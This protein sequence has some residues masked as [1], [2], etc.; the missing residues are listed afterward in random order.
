MPLVLERAVPRDA[1]AIAALRMASAQRL[2][3]RHGEGP[4]SFAT[5]SEGG[6]R[7]EILGSNVF[8]ARCGGR[9]LASL[10]LSMRNPWL[11]DISFFSASARPL[12][13]TSMVVALR[14]Q[15]R[16][17]GRQCLIQALQHARLLNAD[18]VRLDTY[19][20]PAGAEDFY[21]K[22][23]FREVH[24]AE[25]HG[26]PLVWFERSVGESARATAEP[27]NSAALGFGLHYRAG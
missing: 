12:Y 16:G 21:R 13:L 5:E 23:G 8:V 7:A 20:S 9:L 18:V 1:A 2:A 27:Y 3:R 15:G 17:V 10:R 25:Y 4:W 11:G 6:L 19:D 26:T 22:C 14:W 24:R